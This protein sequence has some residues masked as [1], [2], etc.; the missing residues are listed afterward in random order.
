MWDFPNEKKKHLKQMKKALE[1]KKK[2]KVN[3]RF[4]IILFTQV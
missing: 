1:D 3:A 2:V 4:S